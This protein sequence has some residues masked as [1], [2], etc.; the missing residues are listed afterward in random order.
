MTQ[1]S[2]EDLPVSE[3]SVSESQASLRRVYS[4]L[5]TWPEVG[6]LPIVYHRWSNVSFFGLEKWNRFDA[7]KLDKVFNL[8]VEKGLVRDG[9]QPSP[10]NEASEEMLLTVHDASYLEELMMSKMALIR[11]TELLALFLLPNFLIQ[12]QIVTPL[13]FQVAG[14]VL[15]LGIALEKGW[16]IHIGGGMIHASHDR[17]AGWSPFDDLTLAIRFAREHTERVKRVM[18]IDLGAHQ[19]NGYQNN[20][21]HFQDEDLIIVDVYN[22]VIFP[23]DHKARKAINIERQLSCG[24]SGEVYMT[25][26]Q[27]ALKNAAEFDVDVI[28]YAAGTNVLEDDYS[29]QFRVS[30]E[31]IFWRDQLVF[32]FAREKNT[33]ICMVLSS[34]YGKTNFQVVA[35]SIHHL[36]TDLKLI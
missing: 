13:K 10:R 32:E 6:E 25:A 8:L 9:Q 15:A 7:W 26:V 21:L 34:G 17:G 19:G 18:I 4:E 33:P 24:A 20:K 23:Q 5:G 36:I 11:M 31:E 12:K 1:S 22:D 28:L 29:G 16:A 30:R 2:A 14:T 35:D 27:S 3:D